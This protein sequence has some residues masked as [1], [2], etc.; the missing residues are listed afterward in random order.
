VTLFEES[1]LLIV[2]PSARTD[3]G[4]F[5]RGEIDLSDVAD[6]DGIPDMD[7][8][9]VVVIASTSPIQR[10]DIN[11]VL[12]LPAA[13]GAIAVIDTTTDTLIDTIELS[14]EN[15]YAATKGLTVRGDILFVSQ[16]GLF[17]VMDGGIERIDL[18][19]HR[20]EGYFITEDELG[21]DVVDFVMISDRLAYALV[22]QRVSIP[23]WCRSILPSRRCSTRCWP[24]TDSPYSTSGQRS[25][26][27]AVPTAPTQ[28][29]IRI[30][31][32]ST[33]A[34]HEPAAGRRLG[35]V[36]SPLPALTLLV[37]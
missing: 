9:A 6:A 31:G 20:P 21:G 2:N 16:A 26:R 13:N 10:L 8:M 25:R 30:T 15:P 19:A 28:D 22:S 7:L 17:G 14:G 11:S 34:A 23:R 36:R 18:R 5:L 37:A 35:P 12:R 29:G 27:A 24:S 33:G 4:D 32:R 1:R 3:C